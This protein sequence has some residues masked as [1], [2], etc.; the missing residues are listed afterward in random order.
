M[1]DLLSLLSLGSAGIAAQNSGVSIAANNVAN[2]NT[3]GYSRQRV[4]LQSLLAAPL[5]GGV[6]AGSPQRLA[7]NILQSRIRTA[8]GS[9]AMSSAA[10]AALSDVEAR[11]AGGGPTVHQQLGG[12][13]SAFGAVS[14]TPTDPA[15][16]AAV[17]GSAEE[18]AAGIRRR[19][20]ELDGAKA[21][22]NTRIRDNAAQA[23]ELARRLADSN[24][25]VQ[26][27]NDPVARDHR[28]SIATQLSQ[29]VGGSARVD[30]DGQMRFV[31]D[32]GAVLVDGQRAAQLQATTDPVSQNVKLAVVDGGM[33]RDVTGAIGGGA[34][35]ADL[36]VR[37]QTIAKAVS[38]L[39]QLAYDIT[40]SMNATHAAHAGLDGVAGRP[41]FTP[42]AG[43]AGAARSI[44]VDPALADDPDLLAVGAPGRGPGDNTGATALFALSQAKVAS[45]NRTLTGA[46]LD[47]VSMVATQTARAATDVS[48]DEVVGEHLAGLRD[49]LAGVDIQEELTNLARFENVASAMTKFVSTIDDM[50]GTLIDRL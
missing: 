21:D 10:H 26:K 16:R 19:A 6:R 24:L 44:A 31:L 40:S 38:E 32:G 13:F 20:S 42:L 9:L 35:G 1:S 30:A 3:K 36:A 4:D 47:I 34:I 48:R 25:Q 27:T 46:A 22:A 33:N 2:A 49:S 5:V 29:L 50:L 11:V 37:D 18:V 43:V 39:D 7:D 41:M 8:S 14:A 15:A 45:G 23:S 28:D 17:V 12:L